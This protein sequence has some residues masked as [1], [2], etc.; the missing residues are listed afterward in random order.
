MHAGW[1]A[2]QKQFPSAVFKK[3]RKKAR[4]EIWGEIWDLRSQ[5]K[6]RCRHEMSKLSLHELIIESHTAQGF[7][8]ASFLEMRSSKVKNPLSKLMFW[9][10][11]IKISTPVH[12]IL[13]IARNGCNSG[14]AAASRRQQGLSVVG[15]ALPATPKK[16]GSM[17]KTC[18]WQA[19]GKED[20]ETHQS[21]SA[22]NPGLGFDGEHPLLRQNVGT[23]TPQHASAIAHPH[24]SLNPLCRHSPA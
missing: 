18:L 1:E 9:P 21:H 24:V 20:D 4:V 12:V 3:T 15:S 2:V 14:A 8:E 6:T 17:Q 10:A 19:L 16:L 22:D 5:I 7:T 13:L 11:N 23:E